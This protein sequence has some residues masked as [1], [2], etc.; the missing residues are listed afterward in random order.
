LKEE[1]GL[2]LFE[3]F[4]EVKRLHPD[5]MPHKPIWESLCEYYGEAVPYTD[6]MLL[7]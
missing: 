7:H 3:T 6:I 5:A 2:G 4:K 1:E